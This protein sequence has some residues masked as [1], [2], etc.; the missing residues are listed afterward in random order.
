MKHIYI[1]LL[2]FTNL[3]F[4]QIVEEKKEGDFIIKN[5]LN[6]DLQIIKIEKIKDNFLYE[7]IEYLPGGKIKN[8]AFYHKTYGSGNYKKGK[9]ENAEILYIQLLE[10]SSSNWYIDYQNNICIKTSSISTDYY[11]KNQPIKFFSGENK[12][13]YKIPNYNEK[14]IVNDLIECIYSKIKISNFRIVGEIQ[15]NKGLFS[16]HSCTFHEKVNNIKNFVAKLNFNEHGTLHGDQFY[17]KEVHYGL[18]NNYNRDD[19][20]ILHSAKFKDGRPINYIKKILPKTKEMPQ[21]FIDSITFQEDDLKNTTFLYDN[22]I[23]N[24]PNPTLVFNPFSGFVQLTDHYYLYN[25]N[26]TIDVDY[27]IEKLESINYKKLES[28]NKTFI[29]NDL[30]KIIFRRSIEKQHEMNDSSF[31]DEKVDIRNSEDTE[32]DKESNNRKIIFSG[33]A[34]IFIIKENN[35]FDKICNSDYSFVNYAFSSYKYR[36][37]NSNLISNEISNIEF[38]NWNEYF[39][40]GGVQTKQTYFNKEKEAY[41][42]FTSFQGYGDFA[43]SYN[44]TYLLADLNEG[45]IYEEATK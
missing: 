22:S 34:K 45:L 20:L 37:K 9:L 31:F 30:K 21:I 17:L 27:K 11:N 43:H 16:L 12:E 1:F 6:N 36:V 40:R 18:D 38:L 26:T 15:L 24:H 28:S 8:G 39:L 41:G 19:R 7:S 2:L 42:S 13:R 33:K 4:S 35:M 10:D 32:P 23:V 44:P 3:I 5:Y 25:R 29:T 14:K